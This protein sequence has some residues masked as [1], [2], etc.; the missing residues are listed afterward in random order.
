MTEKIEYGQSDESLDDP[1]ANLTFIALVG[2]KDPVRKE[3]PDAVAACKKAGLILKMVTGDNI[4]TACKIARECGILTDGIA[5]EGPE[6]RAMSHDQRADIALNL[7]VLARS[8]PAD[9]HKLVCLLQELGQVVAV[10]GDGTND[11]PA[12]KAADVGFAVCLQKHL[13][14]FRWVSAAHRSRSTLQI[15]CSWMTTLS[16]W[17]S[18]FDGVVTVSVGLFNPSVLDSVRKFLQFQLGVNIV[19]IVLTFVGA[20]STG[21][22]PLNTVQLL[23]VNL[24]MDSLGALA[25]ASDDPD[26][27]VL[28]N[29]PHS[30]TAHMLS[31][32]MKEYMAMQTIYQVT[33]LLIL[34]FSL[35]DFISHTSEVDVLG[36]S[37]RTR[38]AVFNTFVLLQVSN[39]IMCRKLKGEINVFQRFFKNTIFLTV[40]I[41]IVAVQLLAVIYGGEFLDTI[42][43][44]WE[45]W[46]LVSAL[47][48]GNLLFTT[49]LKLGVL[50]YRSSQKE[51]MGMTVTPE[52]EMIVAEKKS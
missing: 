45:E 12:L 32:P 17:F 15:L 26:D 27:D 46:V 34:Q 6:F 10:T 24:I 14:L 39:I 49:L 20:C 4:I 33:V 42:P 8:S 3:V 38:T 51:K 28:D 23:W 52:E 31:T 11:A 16:L 47:S 13:I 18:L 7:Q 29:P 21:Q 1:E 19:A 37:A 36:V 30:R 2:I 48:I 9:K 35:D 25:L 41:I 44:T 50:A 40:V 43:L 5:M 22:S